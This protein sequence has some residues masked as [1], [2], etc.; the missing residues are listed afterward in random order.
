MDNMFS[1]NVPMVTH[2]EDQVKIEE[3]CA[4]WN[5]ELSRD[6]KVWD[7]CW[8]AKMWSQIEDFELPESFRYVIWYYDGKQGQV[9][10]LS[11]FVSFHQ[12]SGCGLQ[13]NPATALL[14]GGFRDVSN[15]PLMNSLTIH[16]TT[17]LIRSNLYLFG[18][19]T[20]GSK[21][22]RDHV[23]KRVHVLSSVTGK[24]KRRKT[25]KVDLE[26]DVWI[27]T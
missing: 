17:A 11:N 18:V 25:H 9:T 3:A 13:A 24:S 5:A 7:E 4:G 1:L 22:T 20:N 12:N 15:S 16:S 10:V 26:A 2:E 14:S 21:K 23:R 27:F 6:D 8:R 19:L